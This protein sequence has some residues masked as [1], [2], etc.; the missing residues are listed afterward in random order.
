[1]ES[2]S[3]N[4][5]PIARLI[6]VPSLITLVNYSFAG[7]PANYGIG[8]PRCLTP[9]QVVEVRSWASRGWF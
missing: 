9:L 3:N 6:L 8:R 5:T 7:L 2:A 4:R 1:M